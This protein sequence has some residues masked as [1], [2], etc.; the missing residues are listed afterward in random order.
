MAERILSPVTYWIVLAI[1]LVLT[2]L[3]VGVSFIPMPGLGHIICGLVIAVIKATL[4]V[5]FFMHVLVSPR[6]TR[7]VIAVAVTW[8]FILF[9]L[10]L[11]DYLTRGDVPFTPGH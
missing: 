10:T 7:A 5:L 6:L 9:S 11:S 2:V 8:I 1:L 3:T 4:V